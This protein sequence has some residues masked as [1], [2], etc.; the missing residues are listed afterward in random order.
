MF[1]GPWM[2]PHGRRG[3]HFERGALKFLVLD[4]LR[5]RPRHGYDIIREIEERTS[6]FY[7]PSPGAVYPT[8]QLLQD[9]GYVV[10]K[11]E[12]GKKVYE[13]TREGLAYLEEHRDRV[14]RH[15]ERMHGWHGRGHGHGPGSA[16]LRDLRKVFRDIG[17]AV[18]R[19]A[20]DP[21]KVE[22]MRA[23]LEET[24]DRLQALADEA[25]GD[26]DARP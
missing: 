15:R 10:C 7:T 18:W 24:R 17:Q 4:L 2:G 22:A 26:E 20:D 21:A 16:G 5:D 11:E 9:Q 8:L 12:D 19:T 23:I 1:P 25:P 14:V 3:G 6:G 13:V